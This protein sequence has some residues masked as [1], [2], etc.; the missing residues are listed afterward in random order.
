MSCSAMAMDIESI[1]TRKSSIDMSVEDAL[2]DKHT[3]YTPPNPVILKE[4]VFELLQN[5]LSTNFENIDSLVKK[6]KR[7]YRIAPSKPD[8]RRCYEENFSSVKIPLI[9]KRWMIKRAVRSHSGV[10]VVTITLSPHVF[11]CRYN[12][13]YCPMET[14]LT[15]KPTQPR[16]YL[17]NE[18][19]MLRALQHNFE[20]KGQFH[21]RIRAYYHTGNIN[22]SDENS[23]K[24]E[25]ILSGGTW[26][27]YPKEY[28][29][30]VMLELYWSA[31]TYGSDRPPKT[32]EEEI[33]ENE[34]AQ[35]RIIGLTIETRPDNISPSSLRD[36]RR[37]GVTRVQ[38]GVQH[39]NDEILRTMN[40]ACYTRHTVRA[41]RYLKQCGF[42]VV[43]H[44]MPDLP[45]SNPELD[46]WMFDQ[47][48]DNPD[49]QFD[50]VKIYPT[51]VCKSSDPNLI[52]H[53]GIGDMYKEGTYVP[54]A[55]KNL[56]DLMDVLI[57]YKSRMN[58]WVRIQRL[59]RDIPAKG[60]EAGYHKMGNLHQIILERMKKNNQ[61]CYCIRNME[62]G[63]ME[64]EN[65]QPYLA[66]RQYKASEGVEYHLSMEAHRMNT[67]AYLKYYWFMF[68]SFLIWMWTGKWRYWSGNLDTYIGLFGFL[69]LRFDPA[70]GGE[71]G[72]IIPELVDCA[73]IREV[74]V[75]GLSL[76]VGTDGIGSQ[77]RGYGKLLMKTAE[78]IAQMNGFKKSAV[79]AGVGTR[80][81]YK[82]KCGYYLGETY[83]LKDLP[84]YQNNLFNR[85]VICSIVTLAI[86]GIFKYFKLF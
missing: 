36:Y 57:H 55:E 58:P 13:S 17:S 48:V 20:V 5:N 46:K 78:N 14:D 84:K 85:F 59:V 21:D 42:K 43:V 3:N 62:I 29:E 7:K 77:H 52:V 50:D 54:Y 60:I 47:A 82:N 24:M 6:L 79:I 27:S 45:G 73:L 11:S 49:Y 35:F 83:M 53:S 76:G 81:Y 80:E 39:Y 9:A 71:E 75:Y 2:E 67:Q 16:S 23:K 30:Q 40:R 34:T 68:V 19:A 25:V 31:N 33:H 63:D 8:I 15:G 61:K 32:L 12:C 41:I 4:F 26:E 74:H 44:L 72:D 56:E 66:V 22:S 70:P 51:A 64:L 28:R 69:R 37:W 1:T 38:I 65:L 10:L 18:P 86:I